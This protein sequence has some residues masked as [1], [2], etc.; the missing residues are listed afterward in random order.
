M[1]K[2]TII[3]ALLQW[4]EVQQIP[5]PRNANEIDNK[6]VTN[7]VVMPFY[8]FWSFQDSPQT[9]HSFL[10]T[11]MVP[12]WKISAFSAE[13]SDFLKCI[14]R[15]SGASHNLCGEKVSLPF[16]ITHEKTHNK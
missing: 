3:Y 13:K 10:Y 2:Q 11:E 7:K 16:E 14:D 1:D 4:A 9:V 12:A 6:G 8:Q 5:D 15:G